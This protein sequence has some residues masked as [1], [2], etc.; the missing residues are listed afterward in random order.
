MTDIIQRDVK[1]MTCDHCEVTVT[2]ALVEAGLEEVEADWRRGMVSG[3]PTAEFTP[4]GAADALG[5]VGYQLA[6]AEHSQAETP[7]A[8]EEDADP[9]YD[10]AIIGSGS[11]AFA[12]AIKATELGGRVVMIERDVIGGTCVNIGCV[13]S[14]ALLRAADHYHRAGRSPFSG[15]ETTAGAVDLAAL[16]AQKDE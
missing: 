5:A 12:A 14:K 16:V 10:L 4:Q 6:E 9:E 15:V 8:S 7:Q 3:R 11:A 13:P 1:G 2:E